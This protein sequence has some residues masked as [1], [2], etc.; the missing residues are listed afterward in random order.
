MA[1]AIAIAALLISILLPFALF[2]ERNDRFEYL[3]LRIRTTS[4]RMRKLCKRI[5]ELE[6]ESQL[7][8]ASEK[9]EEKKKANGKDFVL[10]N[11]QSEG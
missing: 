2:M 6:A 4:M 11:F 8:M 1:L 7:K 10:E 5:R 9:L 3:R